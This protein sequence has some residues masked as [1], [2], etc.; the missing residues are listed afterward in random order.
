MRA[1]IGIPTLSR[2]DLLV[3]NKTFLEGI[4]APDSVLILDNGQQLIDIAVQVERPPEPLSVS[5]SW[6]LLLERAFVRARFDLLILLND[7]IVWGS[8]H[9]KAAKRLVAERRDVDL[10]LSFLQF[11]VQVHRPSN[12]KMI[13]RYDERFPA[14]CNDDDLAIRIVQAKRVWERFEELDP[15]PGSVSEGTPKP[16]PWAD[17]N[18]RLFEK[19]GSRA[20]GVNIPHASYYRTNRGVTN[21][22]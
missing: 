18:R 14:Y 21:Y 16:I 5:A 2:A 10:F 1:L 8:S 15:L 17:A 9:L 19:W 13:G 22:S 12:L 20:F 4:T 7:D 11:S 6:N 3:R